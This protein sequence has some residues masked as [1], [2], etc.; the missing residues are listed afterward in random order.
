MQLKVDA[1]AVTTTQPVK[2]V[3]PAGTSCAHTRPISCAQDCL[4]FSIFFICSVK[5]L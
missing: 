4:L 2:V 3:V 5:F 1:S